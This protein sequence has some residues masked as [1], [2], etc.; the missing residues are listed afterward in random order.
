MAGTS[1]A[2]T[3]ISGIDGNANPLRLPIGSDPDSRG[4]ASGVTNLVRRINRIE[5]PV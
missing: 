4:Q 5:K 2:M 1:P 3:N